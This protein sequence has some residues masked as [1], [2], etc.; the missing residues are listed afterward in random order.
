MN[1]S[2]IGMPLFYGCDRPGVEKGPDILRENNL[3]KILEKNHHVID[4]GNIDVDHIESKDK[5]LE[6]DKLKY[7]KQVVDANNRLAFK[8]YEA[9]TNNTLPFT[10]GGDHSLALGS[11]AGSSKY[12]G[13]DLGVIWID[14][15]GDINTEVT[16]PSGNIHGMPL[17][18]SMGV[19]YDKL[20][21]IFFDSFKVKP[22]NVFILACRDLDQGEV[23]LIDKLKINVWNIDQIQNGDLDKIISD[24]LSKIK[25]K[26]IKNIHLSYDIDCLDPEYVPGT[27]TPV[28][29]GLTF[30]ESKKILKAILGTSLVKSIDFVEYNPEL[31]SNNRTKE[32]CIEL[33]NIISTELK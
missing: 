29:N 4:L 30:E 18:A 7:L 9:L 26:N 14:A 25:E 24:L 2:I 8:V 16:S 17:A 21:S 13:N 31:D 15:H 6:N 10:I 28:D 11:I 33:L 12:F 27:G 19:G 22:E 3:D 20:T 23:E 1:I 5:F 32:T